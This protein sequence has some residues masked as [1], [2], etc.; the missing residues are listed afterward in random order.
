MMSDVGSPDAVEL[1]L[2]KSCARASA[3]HSELYRVSQVS[4]WAWPR[5]TD[6]HEVAGPQ[7]SELKADTALSLR[8][9]PEVSKFVEETASCRL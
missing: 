2:W 5:R 7:P 6:D 9:H 3:R 4:W 8:L 1:G